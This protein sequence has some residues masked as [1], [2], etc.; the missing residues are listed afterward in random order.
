MSVQCAELVGAEITDCRYAP[1]GQRR[2]QTVSKHVSMSALGHKRTFSRPTHHRQVETETRRVF[3][4]PE[5]LFRNVGTG[6]LVRRSSNDSRA[7]ANG[8]ARHSPPPVQNP[9]AGTLK[10]GRRLSY[11][12]TAVTIEYTPG[13]G[14][15]L[16]EVK[17]AVVRNSTVSSPEATPPEPP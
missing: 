10:P 4:C 8:N 1:S 15:C 2:E 12:F 11:G 9:P 5:P 13:K 17:P 7:G 16:G 3:G 6:D 14:I